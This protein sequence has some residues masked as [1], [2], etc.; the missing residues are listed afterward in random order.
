MAPKP[1]GGN[2]EP[3][4]RFLLRMLARWDAALRRIDALE[5]KS[6]QTLKYL[7]RREARDQ[8]RR[9][10]DQERWREQQERWREQQDR[11]EENQKVIR[12]ILARLPRP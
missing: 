2:G 8:E 7:L 5:R 1:N 12:E 10:E 9:R 11:W 3:L 6:D 4:Q